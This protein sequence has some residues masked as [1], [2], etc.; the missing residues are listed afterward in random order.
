M[1]IVLSVTNKESAKLLFMLFLILLAC[2]FSPL[3]F[4]DFLKLS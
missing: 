4:I 1:V 3:L 2:S